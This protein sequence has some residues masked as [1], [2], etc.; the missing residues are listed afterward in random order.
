MLSEYSAKAPN[1]LSLSTQ[2]W[3]QQFSATSALSKENRFQVPISFKDTVIEVLSSASIFCLPDHIHKPNKHTIKSSDPLIPLWL[4]YPIFLLY[5]NLQSKTQE[6]PKL[7]IS[8]PLFHHLFIRTFK[9]KLK[10]QSN[11]PVKVISYYCTILAL[12]VN[13]ECIY[14]A[15]PKNKVVLYIIPLRILP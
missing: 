7:W 8:F 14:A 10:E 6:F 4:W 12:H 9:R 2:T 11:A 3:F 5:N 13:K 1:S 15:A